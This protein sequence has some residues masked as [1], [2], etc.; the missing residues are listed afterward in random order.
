MLEF[1]QKRPIEF[2]NDKNVLL[3]QKLAEIAP[4]VLLEHGKSKNPFPNVDSA[5]GILFYHYGIRELLFFTV[6]FGCSRAMG[7]LTQLVWDRIL[8]LPIER[9]KSLNLE[10]LEALTKASNV[11][12]L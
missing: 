3:M 7:P 1:A 2:E 6:I 4:K 12:K 9:P 11:N 10:G 8:G 5:S